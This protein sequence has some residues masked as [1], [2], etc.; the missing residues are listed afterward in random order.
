LQDCIGAIDGVH[1]KA[2]IPPEDQVPYIGRK[3]IPT[4][5]IMATCNFDMQFIFASASWEAIAHDTRVFLSSLRNNAL[6]FSKPPNG[7]VSN[8]CISLNFEFLHFQIIL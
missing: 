6:N 7:N 5:N 2:S 1:V 3:E 8:M 4:Q